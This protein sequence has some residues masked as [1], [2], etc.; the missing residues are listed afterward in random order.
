MFA[1][2]CVYGIGVRIQQL[3]FKW[4]KSVSYKTLFQLRLKPIRLEANIR[5]FDLQTGED[6]GPI[7]DK[8]KPS[9][10]KEESKLSASRCLHL[11]LF[12]TFLLV[13]IIHF[14]MLVFVASTTSPTMD[15]PAHLAAG[16]SHWQSGNFDA[17]NVHPPLVR[18][19]AALP[20]II[21]GYEKDEGMGGPVVQ[22]RPEFSKGREFV[23]RNGYRTFFLMM[24]ARYAC[25]PF[26]VLAAV[27]CFFWGKELFGVWSG[28]LAGILWCF[29]PTVLAHAS[30]ITP[31]AHAAA[32][33]LSASYLFW[34]WLRHRTWTRA[35]LVGLVLGF[36]LL[37][38]TTMVLLLPSFLLLYVVSRLLHDQRSQSF[39][40]LQLTFILVFSICILNF[41]YLFEGSFSSLR[42]YQFK[43]EAFVNF[44]RFTSIFG[45]L[46]VPLPRNYVS[47]VDLQQADFEAKR[48]AYLHGEWQNHGWWYYYI[49]AFAIK[50]PIGIL[51]IGVIALLDPFRLGNT[52]ASLVDK[53]AILTPAIV[54]FVVASAKT[55][56]SEHFRYVLLCMPFLFVF[57]GKALTSDVWRSPQEP[58]WGKTIAN[59]VLVLVLLV[60]AIGSSLLSVRDPIAYFNE[61]VDGRENGT[62]FVLSGN[63]DLGQGLLQLESVLNAHPD[64]GPIAIS[65]YGSYAPEDVGSRAESVDWSRHRPLEGY[66]HFVVSNNLLAGHHFRSS[67]FNLEQSSE[68]LFREISSAQPILRI[69]GSLTVFDL[70]ARH[71]Q[72]RS[73]AGKTPLEK[74]DFEEF[75]VANAIPGLG[76][77]YDGSALLSV[78]ELLHVLLLN[79]MGD[80]G[81]HSPATGTEALRILTDEQQAIEILGASP[82]VRTRNGIRYRLSG[83]EEAIPGKHIGETHRDQC[84]SVFAVLGLPLT[85]PVVL[86]EKRFTVAD[87]L[88]ESVANFSL[89]QHEIEWT[90]VSYASYIPP[91]KSWTNRFGEKTSFSE[92]LS[93][94]IAQ[95]IEGRSCAGTHLLQAIMQIQAADREHGI[96]EPPARI[97]AR[98][99]MED[100]LRRIYGSQQ[101][102]GSWTSQWHRSGTPVAD[103]TSFQYRL[104]VVGHMLEILPSLRDFKLATRVKATEWML[105]A[106]KSFPDNKQVFGICPLTHALRGV[107]AS[108]ESRHEF[109]EMMELFHHRESVPLTGGS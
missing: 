59:A 101:L 97:K 7:I 46:P 3:V 70:Q 24:I 9:S 75:S 16:L 21:A 106:L 66:S 2:D 31:D 109:F 51:A 90:A 14:C 48:P 87:L 74:G 98:H 44:T 4:V 12:A 23:V 5:P 1:V 19:V 38:K 35:C 20:V 85:T 57:C 103:D 40:P 95:D 47:G 26:S 76:D 73:N 72:G 91:S 56:F 29:S 55:E 13:I 25:L 6:F 81:L 45:D 82:L 52:N 83:P 69:G 71:F 54:V 61:F 11:L 18:L 67:W 80:T 93:F 10:R 64:W 100:T 41:G 58:G 27:A 37:A 96:L 79:G 88:R 77:L 89:D 108:Y 84:L 78:S 102:D 86:K 43:S 39:K 65:Y 17:Y 32:L 8:V 22:G 50:V 92:L 36:A 53:M 28:L 104:I 30:L 94:L 49:Y 42:S 99:F 34:R 63:L 68:D 60:W 107:R 105:D 33:G 62:K 15:E